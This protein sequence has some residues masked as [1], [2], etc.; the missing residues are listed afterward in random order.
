MSL[1]TRSYCRSYDDYDGDKR[2]EARRDQCDDDEGDKRWDARRGQSDDDEGDKRWEARR[3]Q[4]DDDEGR[5]DRSFS[6]EPARDDE[7]MPEDDR[8]VFLP[9]LPDV[10]TGDSLRAYFARFGEVTDI[11]IPSTKSHERFGFVTFQTAEQAKSALSFREGHHR[12]NG[13]Y[14]RIR[15][16]E[17]RAYKR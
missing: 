4:C 11:F 3:D 16:A 5:D 2:W 8:R 7:A 12:I 13:D 17:P 9:R 1:P 6:P 15:K 10:A 14:C